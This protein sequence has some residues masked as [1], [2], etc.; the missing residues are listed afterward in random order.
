MCEE[1]FC[2]VSFSFIFSHSVT[3]ILPIQLLRA[4]DIR[5]KRHFACI[6][7]CVRLFS[8]FFH[9]HI[10]THSL[11]HSL[12][13]YKTSRWRLISRITLWRAQDDISECSNR[14]SSIH[15]LVCVLDSCFFTHQKTFCNII[16]GIYTRT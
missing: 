4:Q 12:C 6:C 3:F 2:V 16:L 15:N 14:I 9:S 5:E 1:K 11:S 8:I 10:F 7:A 13:V